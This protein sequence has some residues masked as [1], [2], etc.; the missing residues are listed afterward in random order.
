MGEYTSESRGTLDL[1]T[2]LQSKLGTELGILEVYPQL[3]LIQKGMVVDGS[4]KLAHDNRV[5]E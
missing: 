2:M 1:N 3:L 4:P 5:R